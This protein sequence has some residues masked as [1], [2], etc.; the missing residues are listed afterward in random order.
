MHVHGHDHLHSHG[1]L[2]EAMSFLN[3]MMQPESGCKGLKY[4]VVD[5]GC[6]GGF[7]AHFQLAASDWLRK[8]AGLNYT[9]PVIIVGS[10]R[11][12]S[13][14]PE[15]AKVKSDWTCYF[16]PMSSCQEELIA[17]GTRIT[18]VPEIDISDNSIPNAFRHLGLPFWWG[19]VQ[20]R[21][22]RVQNNVLE[23]IKHQAMYMGNNQHFPFYQSIAGLHVRH[24]DKK[25]DGFKDHSFESEIIAIK[26]SP[27]C[28]SAEGKSPCDNV[29]R[30]YSPGKL[31]IFVASDDG[32][33]LKSAIK[34]GY[35]ADD[36]GISQQT[37][38]AGMY[39]SLMSHP[40][41]GFNASI[42]IITDVFF[43]SQC[44]TLVGIAASQ[45]FRMSV[46][47][48]NATGRLKY[49]VAMDY[50]QLPK[51]QRMSIKYGL[52]MP[53]TFSVNI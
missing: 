41:W 38:S 26:R 7:A 29:E 23:H 45:V 24:G 47:I 19:V 43:L 17:T 42:E 27:D 13:Q 22:F 40:E 28:V 49:A 10:I 4:A 2:K 18:N 52:P 15:C 16:H 25:I 20:F 30:G 51:I 44:S 33:V 31:P 5:M 35:L 9:V 12:Y 14:G 37:N 50:N 21:M 39:T 48:S 11:G 1:P 8:A 46:D 34:L 36:A 53:E 3:N 6:G 32:N